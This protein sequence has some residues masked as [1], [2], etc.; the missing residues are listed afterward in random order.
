PTTDASCTAAAS[1]WAREPATS[2]ADLLGIGTDSINRTIVSYILRTIVLFIAHEWRPNADQVAWLGRRGDRGA[3][4][5]G[6]RRSTPGAGSRV[7]V[8]RG[9]SPGDPAP[10]SRPRPAWGDCGPSPAPR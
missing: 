10:S 8:A 2:V 7:R 9:T 6:G 4:R 5:A 1:V 3:R